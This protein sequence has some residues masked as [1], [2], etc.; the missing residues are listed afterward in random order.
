VLCPDLSNPS[1]SALPLDWGPGIRISPLPLDAA[2]FVMHPPWLFGDLMHRE[3][4]ARRPFAFHCHDLTT[5][6]IGLSAA[7]KT[8]ARCV[9]DFHEWYSENVSWNQ[10]AAC[11]EPHP[12]LKRLAYRL[13]ERLVLWRADAVIT[14]C[15]SIA[16]ELSETLSSSHRHV[17]VIRNIPSLQR[18]DAVSYPPLRDTLKISRE[19]FLL[20]WQGGTG[21]SR[22]IEPIIQALALAPRVTFVIRGPSLDVYGDGYLRLA[23]EHGVEGRLRLLPPVPS[24]DVVVA[25][26][27]ADA[28]I[29]TLPNLSKNFYYALPNKIFEYLASGLPVLAANFPEARRMVEGNDV[30]LCFDP[31]DPRSIAAQLNRL[32]DDPGLFSRLRA[33]IPAALAAIDADNEW[34][35]LVAVYDRLSGAARTEQA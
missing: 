16:R 22:M 14:V 8:K 32:T 10:A 1:L 6:I 2:S 11:W 12:P 17:E 19:Q 35:K 3:A 23:R 21:P 26:E 5:A 4:S 24:Q 28:G 15:D 34:N 25:A 18:S 30:G 31:Y 20:L 9:C 27:S 29:W 7:R 33:N 13:A